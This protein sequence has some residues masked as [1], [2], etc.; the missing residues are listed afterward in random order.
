MLSNTPGQEEVTMNLFNKLF[1]KDLIFIDF[2][3]NSKEDFFEKISSILLEK[4]YVKPTF[5]AAIME[6]ERN[7]PTG[8]RTVP[9]HVAIPH[10]DPE[11]IIKPFITVIRPVKPIEFFE[12]GT[13]DVLVQAQI[14]FLLGIHK[15]EAQIPLL[16]SLMEMFM[17]ESVMN[18]LI[19]INDKSTL[20]QILKN[21]IS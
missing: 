14:M 8:L 6:R 1:T 7:F 3:C 10:T 4:G 12:M 17:E 18:E 5:K 11:N 9:F 20:L 2:D 16:Q 13:D 19:T 15:S 21:Q